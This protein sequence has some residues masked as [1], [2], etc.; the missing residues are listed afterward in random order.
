MNSI[1]LESRRLALRTF[2][3]A[4]AADVF[5]CITPAITRFMTWEPPPSQGAF[6]D[7]WQSWLPAIAAQND[8]YFVIRARTNGQ[9]LGIAALHA[10]RTKH[11]ELGIWLRADDHGKGFG[12]EAVT[13]VVRWASKELRPDYFEY[14]VAEQNLASRRIAI[15]LGGS[16]REHR[17]T[18]KYK[19]VVYHIP[20][21]HPAG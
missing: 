12:K 21:I 17:S 19:S 5:A 3:A 14:P 11:S 4:D 13:A 10:M 16:V 8:H 7:T 9:C 6:A 2:E 18:P 15:S 1:V 20:A